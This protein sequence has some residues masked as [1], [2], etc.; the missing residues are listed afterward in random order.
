MMHYQT[1]VQTGDYF[2]RNI[3]FSDPFSVM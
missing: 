2:L 3:K 1:T